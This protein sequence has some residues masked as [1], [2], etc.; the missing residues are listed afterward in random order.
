MAR[1][2]ETADRILEAALVSFG[3]RGY[4]ATSLDQLAAGLGI[5]KQTILY[6]YGGKEKL[7]D[8]AID[9][10]ADEVAS[11]LERSLVR[12]GLGFARIEAIV[13][14]VFRLSARRPELIGLIREVGRLGP[15]AA[16]RLRESLEPLAARAAAFLEAEMDAGRL[17]RHPPRLLLLAAYSMVIG[18]ASDVEVL[19]A[20]GE[21]TSTRALVRRRREL[22]DLLRGALSP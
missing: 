12:A 8:A 7:L 6:W 2:T 9:R 15:P 19:R 4:E 22:L 5:T 18:V 16:D 20:L 3:T 13:T 1:S 17:R 14:S 21:E 11:S 10:C